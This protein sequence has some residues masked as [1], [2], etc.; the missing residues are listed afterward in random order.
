M[1]RLETSLIANRSKR[2][3]SALGYTQLSR[4]THKACEANGTHRFS[5]DSKPLVEQVKT[6]VFSLIFDHNITKEQLSQ[7]Q[8]S[9]KVVNNQL[10]LTA[11]EGVI[12]TN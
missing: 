12:W 4:I 11:L 8:K 7:L 10:Q 1:K 9:I 6:L 5:K 2:Q 3:L